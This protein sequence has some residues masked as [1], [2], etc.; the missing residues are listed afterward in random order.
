MK[1]LHGSHYWAL[2]KHQGY[3]W[4]RGDVWDLATSSN[5]EQLSWMARLYT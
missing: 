2:M 5:E 4:E 3:Y 1:Q